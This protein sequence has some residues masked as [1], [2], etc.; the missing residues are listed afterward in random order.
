MFSVIAF[1][2]D[3]SGATAIEYT[4]L[5][6]MIALAIVGILPLI[7]VDLRDKFQTIVNAFN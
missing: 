6:A 5:A 7:G 2:R 3:Q 4:F 1:W